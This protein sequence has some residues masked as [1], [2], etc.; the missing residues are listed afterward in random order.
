MSNT[1]AHAGQSVSKSSG[2]RAYGFITYAD[3]QVCGLETVEVRR[4]IANI[5]VMEPLLSLEVL[6][7]VEAGSYYDQNYRQ[8]GIFL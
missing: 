7:F 3:A 1:V 2:T 4:R 8:V 5:D 6:E